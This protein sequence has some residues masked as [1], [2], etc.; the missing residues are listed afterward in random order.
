MF[1]LRGG[2]VMSAFMTPTMSWTG[3]LVMG[4]ET[5]DAWSGEWTYDFDII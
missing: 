2:K 4:L 3:N 1:S 5:T